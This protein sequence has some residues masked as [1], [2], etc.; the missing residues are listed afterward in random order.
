[1]LGHGLTAITHSRQRAGTLQA[2]L[3]APLFGFQPD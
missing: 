3:R 1:M 2:L